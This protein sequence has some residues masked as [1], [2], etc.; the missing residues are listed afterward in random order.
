[1]ITACPIAFGEVGV[2]ERVKSMLNYKKP[3]FWII[4]VAVVALIVT[5]VCLLTNP[6]TNEKDTDSPANASIVL[7]DALREKY[8]QYFDLSTDKGLEVYIWQ[9]G[10]DLYY[11]GL[12]SGTNR[13]KT[14]EE[15]WDLKGTSINEMKIILSTYSIPKSDV[16]VIPFQHPISSYYREITDE[17]CATLREKLGLT[18]DPSTSILEILAAFK[19]CGIVCEQVPDDGFLTGTKYTYKIK[20]GKDIITLYQY[21][22]AKEAETDSKSVSKD[23]FSISLTGGN[24]LG[25]SIEIDWISIPHWY[26][27]KSTIILYV[28]EDRS[29]ISALNN[30]CGNAFAGE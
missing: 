27:H 21:N 26:L 25:K 6:K 23:G 4:I 1:M 24:E 12:M 17:Y 13:N 7:V 14:S 9:M 20:G 29:V 28:G 15:L 22:T 5:A 8:P 10:K 11:C 3:T 2:K 18:N 16:V 30:I 19:K